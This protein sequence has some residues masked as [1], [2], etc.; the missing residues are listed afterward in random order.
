LLHKIE[1]SYG[2]LVFAQIRTSATVHTQYDSANPLLAGFPFLHCSESCFSKDLAG[3]VDL[4]P[5]C[6]EAAYCLSLLSRTRWLPLQLML[7]QSCSAT[8]VSVLFLQLPYVKVASGLRERGEK[9]C[10]MGPVR[11]DDG[12]RSSGSGSIVLYVFGDIHSLP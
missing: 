5:P 6:S 8:S 4:A 9:T 3:G 1:C 12:S 11:V 2:L 7:L 10:V